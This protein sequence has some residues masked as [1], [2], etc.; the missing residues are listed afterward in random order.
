MPQPPPPPGSRFARHRTRSAALLAPLAALLVGL[1][2]AP[3][4]AGDSGLIGDEDT[5]TGETI[6]RERRRLSEL[7]VRVRAELTGFGQG[8]L[9]GSGRTGFDGAGR[10]DMLVGADTERMGL[11]T[12]GGLHTH[13]EYRF[14]NLGSHR[15]GA[16]LPSNAGL[17]LP[18]LTEGDLVATSLYLSQRLGPSTLL[19]VGKINPLDLIAR[20]P[21]YGGWGVH[22]FMNLAFVA[23]PAGVMPAVMMGAIV[24]HAIGPWRLS[25]VLADPDDK[26]DTY[27]FHGLFADGADVSLTAVWNGAVRGRSTYAG[28]T[29]A[30]TTKEAFDPTDAGLPADLQADGGRRAAHNVTV[31][32]GH[33]LL[34]SVATAGQGLGIYARAGYGGGGSNPIRASFAGGFAGHGIVPH[35]P[36]DSFGIGYYRFRFDGSLY[37]AV[38]GRL[39]AA[40]EQ[41]LELFYSVAL[42]R[43]FRLTVDLQVIDPPAAAASTSVIGGIRASVL[44]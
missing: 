9:S 35:R 28:I 21:F 19:L 30:Y 25:A 40:D 26:T 23:P 38:T 7:G 29:G 13:L 6:P 12:G 20:D 18:L 33:L 15:G 11:W 24:N 1:G 39:G 4:R 36:R 41:G 37:R 5:L 14:G 32:A 31:Q 10:F 2:P 3:A 17:T 43:W 8:V 44:F 34:E 16:L 42:T 22:G 27:S